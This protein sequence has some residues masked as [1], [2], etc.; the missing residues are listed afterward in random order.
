[1]FILIEILFSLF[2]KF[3]HITIHLDFSLLVSKNLTLHLGSLPSVSMKIYLFLPSGLISILFS[4]TL[5]NW[6]CLDS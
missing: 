6:L 1:M 3:H 5:F 4:T 2:K